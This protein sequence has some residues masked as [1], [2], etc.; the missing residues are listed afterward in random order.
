M[1]GDF[2]S[3]QP[4]ISNEEQ[5]LLTQQINT[6][7]NTQVNLESNAAITIE[8]APQMNLENAH[9][10]NTPS[11]TQ[12]H[13]INAHEMK[14]G[15][16]PEENLGIGKSSDIV[17][18]DNQMTVNVALS[19]QSEA[20]NHQ[21]E[22]DSVTTSNVE[23]GESQSIEQQNTA[24]NIMNPESPMFKS[25]E[26]IN[27][28]IPIAGI[29]E[30]SIV[31]PP[32]NI[33]NI[34]AT[35]QLDEGTLHVD[36]G[37]LESET[38][39]KLMEDCTDII[40]VE[41]QFDN[42]LNGTQDKK[43]INRNAQDN[44][45]NKTESNT[46]EIV[47]NKHIKNKSAS[48]RKTKGNSK[49]TKLVNDLTE[50]KISTSIFMKRDRTVTS[51][52]AV[53]TPSKPTCSVCKAS[54]SRIHSLKGHLLIKHGM[55]VTLEELQNGRHT[56]QTESRNKSMVKGEGQFSIS[57]DHDNISDFDVGE[58]C[59]SDEI[60]PDS[61]T[62]IKTLEK[63]KLFERDDKRGVKRLKTD[64]CESFLDEEET[65]SI[66]EENHD[67]NVPKD[68]NKNVKK[69]N[70]YCDICDKVFQ[71]EIN[72]TIHNIRFHPSRIMMQFGVDMSGNS[73]P[74]KQEPGDE[75]G[76]EVGEELGSFEETSVKLEGFCDSSQENNDICT[77]NGV[78]DPWS[79]LNEIKQN[80][81]IQ[82]FMTLS[83]VENDKI[84]INCND[85]DYV[86]D[87]FHQMLVHLAKDHTTMSPDV[88]LMI[89]CFY[90]VQF[91]NKKCDK[92]S[93]SFLSV[94]SLWNHITK[95]H[96]ECLTDS[97]KRKLLRDMK[98][99][100]KADRVDTSYKCS[101]C[102]E[103]F[104][105]IRAL[106][107]HMKVH[108]YLGR[109]YHCPQCLQAFS[110]KP[111]M[112]RH[113]KQIHLDEKKF[114]CDVCG[115]S[116]KQKATLKFHR[117]THEVE[118]PRLFECHICNKKLRKKETLQIHLRQHEGIKPYVCEICGM[119]FSQNGN[120]NK[121]KQLI[122]N[123]VRSL[124]CEKCGKTF[125][126]GEHL[127]RH[128]KMHLIREDELPPGKSYACPVEGC[129]AR[130]L[131]FG[132]LKYHHM[133][134][135][136]N[137]RPFTCG[138]CGKGFIT[139]DKLS[140]HEQIHDDGS[141]G[142]ECETCP[143]KFTDK[144]SLVMHTKYHEVCETDQFQ[145]TDNYDTVI[146]PQENG[147]PIKVQLAHSEPI[148][149]ETVDITEAANEDQTYYIRT[150]GEEDSV[151]V[152]DNTILVDPGVLESVLG[153]SSDDQTVYYYVT[154]S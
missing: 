71:K 35:S 45:L 74:I 137:E 119:A 152:D 129:G 17:I 23:H 110:T 134:K 123:D 94:T 127:K 69:S 120:R 96:P 125:K 124:E 47:R 151:Q 42:V 37:L 106:D 93:K 39:V 80:E 31:V 8:A 57:V 19:S 130:Y 101:E 109:R 41:T 25:S 11:A 36:S 58:V 88:D 55:E 111:N 16:A 145:V 52:T 138:T 20:R 98:S 132:Q 49:K 53:A 61:V 108:P 70:V 28:T 10:E 38:T 27:N 67:E 77:F 82:K 140:R 136:T 64:S 143:K 85:C 48:P 79:R 75:T 15:D 21:L 76:D 148:P 56:T 115:K 146:I 33:N 149:T 117:T 29:T 9:E 44:H 68:K 81:E 121:H 87:E 65:P 78:A 54:F 84:I 5:N 86:C 112:M 95:S 46:S 91:P 30:K 24:N 89:K 83:E 150:T 26:N 63:R 92:C 1:I 4:V 154:G 18:V 118:K 114:Q 2:G 104:N 113:F 141:N 139:R 128:M 153:A 135:H 50:S 99:K 60:A 12:N 7:D 40:H 34:Q 22:T 147:A 122:H 66:L 6:D 73:V 142:F 131:S 51:G 107:C 59:Q 144:E 103:V 43:I 116:F 105:S 90:G 72:L 100:Y 102:N 14:L 133:A 126:L 97:S 3:E 62:E 13:Y 32:E